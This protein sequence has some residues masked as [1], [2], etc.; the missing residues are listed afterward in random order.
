[1]D[2]KARLELVKRNVIE[3]LNP[4]NLQKLLKGKKKPVAYCGYEVS[5][6]IHVGHLVTITKLMDLQRAGFHV[7]V[8]FADWHTWLN[9]KGEWKFIHEQTKAWKKGFEA[10]G[11]KDAE[12]IL[13][14]E[15]QRK[16]EYI[17]DVLLLSL[18]TTLNRS[19]RSMQQV[20]REIETAKVSQVIYPL[21]Q[22]ADIKHLKVDIA[23]G[24]IEQRKIHALAVET[25]NDIGYE[26]P[27]FIHTPLICSLKGPGS[28]MSSSVPESM[29]SIRDSKEEISKKIQNAYC[30]ASVVEENPI[31]DILKLIIFPRAKSFT[32]RRDKKY[33]GN[34]EF[35]DY[36]ELERD[37][38]ENK[39][40]PL[41][42]KRAVAD[43]LDEILSE[44]RKN[45]S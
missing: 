43:R 35:D 33:G 16:I 30:N 28:K 15:F 8:L 12:Y 27:V 22:I 36:N 7:N 32:I 20:G 23:Y 41:D 25:L 1:M 42:L 34:I 37:F 24:G 10:A 21:M 5:G 11:L 17:D 4:E 45:F 9:R 18:K 6:E 3:V 19:L 2:E 14:S 26:A 40:H 38:A 13:G 29:I 31:L 39:I 44:I